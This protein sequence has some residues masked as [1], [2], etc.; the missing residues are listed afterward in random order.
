MIVGLVTARGGSKRIPGK[1]S[2][3][4]GGRPLISWTITAALN[5]KAIDKVILSTENEEIASIARNAGADVPFIRPVELASDEANHY[6]VISHALDWID[7]QN[8]LLEA[9]VLLQ[10]TSPFRTEKH[11]DEAIALWRSKSSDSLVSVCPVTHHPAFMFRQQADGSLCSFL[12][13]SEGYQRSQ[14]QEPLYVLNGA[15]YVLAPKPFRDRKTVLGASPTGY[16]MDPISSH[17]IDTPDDW[18]IAETLFSQWAKND[19]AFTS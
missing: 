6:D 5:A 8:F 17:D 14:D 18:K 10:P 11:I 4:L 13:P 1:N 15:I 7:D 2:R 3:V 9:I 19:E 12:P 16:V